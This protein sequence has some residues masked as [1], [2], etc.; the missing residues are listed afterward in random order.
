MKQQLQE[1]LSY[2]CV[3]VTAGIYDGAGTIRV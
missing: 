1:E 3:R 2:E